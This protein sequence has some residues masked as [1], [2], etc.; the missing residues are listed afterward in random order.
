M[1]RISDLLAAA[2]A[3]LKL[4]CYAP[5]QALTM[6]NPAADV[7]SED[8]TDNT[9]SVLDEIGMNYWTGEG[10]TAKRIG[11][12]LRKIGDR[13]VVVNINSPGGSFFEGLAIYNALR[14]HPHNVTVNVIGVAASAASII[15]MAGD[16]INIAKAGFLMNHNTMIGMYGNKET[17][18]READWLE[19]FDD[20]AAEIF[21][22]RSGESVESVKAELA[23]ATEDGVW[24]SGAKAVERGYADDLLAVDVEN[25]AKEPDQSAQ[26]ARRHV[27][28]L[29][30]L[31]NYTR[32]E[33]KSIQQSLKGG[34][35]S[36]ASTDTP[37][38]V[39]ATGVKDLL[40]T[41]RQHKETPNV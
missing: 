9:I 40:Q 11:A 38:A 34:T 16:T 15:A 1:N 17:F 23:A 5:P 31:H 35:P 33:R 20:V 14:L 29:L 19:Q 4:S 3:R 24:L 10:V 32:S 26:T 13:D 18:R 8:K 21:A 25:R 7:R 12:A 28:Q 6:W 37:S 30:A 2:P 41:I 36:A 39:D 22:D 27:D